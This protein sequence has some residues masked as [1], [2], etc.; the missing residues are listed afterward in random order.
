MLEDFRLKVF[1][2]VVQERSFTKAASVLGITQQA[3]SQNVADL[4]KMTGRKL[5][6]RQKGS[7]AL[8]AEGE[9]FLL[10]VEELLK[11]CASVDDMFSKVNPAVVKIA[12]SEEIYAYLVGPALESF[13]KVHPDVRFERCLFG[14]A[15]LTIVLVPSSLSQASDDVISRIRMSVFVPQQSGSQSSSHEK[16]S[17][18]DVV[19]RPSQAFA[20][21]RL[22]RL[23]RQFLAK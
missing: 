9:V 18:Y 11:T 2:A 17:Y 8:T 4:E 14:D 16:T 20:I 5:F 7:V 12:A 21:T 10:Y 13:S 22:C 6:D 19:Y 15:D 1:M 3:V 23:I